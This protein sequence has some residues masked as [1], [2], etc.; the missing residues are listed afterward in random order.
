MAFNKKESDV[1]LKYANI[2]G[3]ILANLEIL[4]IATKYLDSEKQEF[5]DLYNKSYRENCIYLFKEPSKYLS[6]NTITAFLNNNQNLKNKVDLYIQ[7]YLNTDLSKNEPL[8]NKSKYY[9]N[10]SIELLKIINDIVDESFK[11]INNDNYAQLKNF[12]YYRILNAMS[13]IH[14]TKDYFIDNK[15]NII[16]PL[17]E[18]VTQFKNSLL[19]LSNEGKIKN[20]LIK[21]ELDKYGGSTENKELSMKSKLENIIKNMSNNVS[22]GSKKINRKKAKSPAKKQKSPKNKQKSPKKKSNKN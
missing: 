20:I 17:P 19:E 3:F 21:L 12:F 13:D 1:S 11:I 4:L 7:N 8:F 9:Y 14:K 10:R 16:N 15:F 2:H 6:Y 18:S 22:G 5:R